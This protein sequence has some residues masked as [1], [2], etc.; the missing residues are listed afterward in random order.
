M[1]GNRRWARR[2]GLDSVSAGHQ[3]GAEHLARVLEWCADLGITQVTAFVCSA[4]NLRKRDD[5]EVGFLMRLA[6]QG[7]EQR[8]A[9]PDNRWRL[10]LAGQLDILPDSTARA[11]K[12]AAAATQDRAGYDLTLAI[13]YDGRTE[14]ADAVRG[15]LD[16]AAR[17]GETVESLA[18]SLDPERIAAHLYTGGLPDPDLVIRTS[19]EQRLGG[20][21]LWQTAHSEL[22]F[23]DVYWP[24]FRRVDFLR[25]LRSYAARQA[26]FADPA[27]PAQPVR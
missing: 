27:P 23:C 19:G 20:F 17:A 2:A 22:Y 1:D 15:L 9:R 7:V 11:L 25:A 3:Q 8:L 10:H 16:D 4:D 5:G 18:A 26:R 12:A 24:G 13:G 21:L 14:I 6:E